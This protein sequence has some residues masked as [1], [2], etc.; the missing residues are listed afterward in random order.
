MSLSQ[1]ACLM[2]ILIQIKDSKHTHRSSFANIT[3]VVPSL[4]YVLI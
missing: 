4:M 1:V 3:N 2:Y